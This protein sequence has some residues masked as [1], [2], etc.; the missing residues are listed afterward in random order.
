M[1][2]TK[3]ELLAY[4]KSQTGWND[5][6]CEDYLLDVQ[7]QELIKQLEAQK[8]TTFNNEWEFVTSL[9]PAQ[10][11]FFNKLRSDWED[12]ATKWSEKYRKLTSTNGDYKQKYEDLRSTVYHSV[13]QLKEKLEHKYTD[14]EDY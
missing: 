6:Q 12:T 9:T 5:K 10:Q 14:D 2:E 8:R 3:E 7:R 13:D 11:D 1:A 4:I